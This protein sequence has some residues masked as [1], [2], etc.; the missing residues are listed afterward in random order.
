MEPTPLKKTEISHTPSL[1]SWRVV[2]GSEGT[3]LHQPDSG[4]M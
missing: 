1:H 3:V 4:D 2:D